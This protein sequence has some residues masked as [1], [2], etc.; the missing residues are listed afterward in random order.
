MTSDELRNIISGIGEDPERDLIK[1]ALLHLRTSQSSS[2]TPEKTKFFS[3]KDEIIDL[4][5]FAEKNQCWYAIDE[6]N[7]IGEGAEQRV[8]LSND[9]RHVIKTNDAIFYEKWED[10]LIN[11]LIH[12]VLFPATSYDLIGFCWKEDVFCAVVRQ[13]FIVSSQPT[14][15]TL[16]KIFLESNGFKHKKNND[17]YQPDWGI[18]LEDLHDENVLTNE[19]VFFFI[20]TVIYLLP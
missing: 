17:Y 18:L 3:K 15:L 8:Y 19:N 5:V 6:D 16:L 10:Y 1:A 14:D 4:S 11:L 20:D 2:R 12:N 13:P 7:Y 9:G